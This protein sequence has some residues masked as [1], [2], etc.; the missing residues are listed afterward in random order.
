VT[1]LVTSTALLLALPLSAGLLLAVVRRRMLL[2]TVAGRSMEPALRPGDV[3]WVRRTRLADV[4]AGQLVV[5]RDVPAQAVD[6]G[7]GGGTVRRLLMVKRA[8]ALPGDPVPQDPELFVT[9][10]PG[11]VVPPDR[12]VV[13]GD[14]ASL[15]YDSRHYGYLGP[16]NLVGVVVGRRLR[17]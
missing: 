7:T 9:A 8:V 12:M 2:V 11:S 17:A 13:L 3:V 5:V 4:S 6:G 14:N 16:G 10:A 1:V 15:S